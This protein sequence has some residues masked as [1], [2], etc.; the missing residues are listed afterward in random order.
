MTCFSLPHFMRSKITAQWIFPIFSGSSCY[1]SSPNF[2]LISSPYSKPNLHSWGFR[3]TVCLVVAISLPPWQA[4]LSKRL[5]IA[6]KSAHF[7]K[8]RKEMSIFP[9]RIIH[10]I[11]GHATELE[12]AAGFCPQQS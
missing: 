11:S 7:Q 2:S 1:F 3:S 9:Q 4:I 10:S 6:A 8:K 5:Q 12:K